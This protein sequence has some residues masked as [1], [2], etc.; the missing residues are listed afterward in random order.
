MQITGTTGAISLDVDKGIRLAEDQWIGLGSTLERVQFDGSL[1]RIDIEAADVTVDDGKWIGIDG[2]SPRIRYTD[3]APGILDVE[4]ANVR[5]DD[6]TWFGLGSTIERFEFQGGD[7]EVNLMGAELGIGTLAPSEALD[8]NGQI[9]MRT[10]GA[11]GYIPVSSANGTMTWTD[12]ATLGFDVTTASNGL[13]EVVNDIQLG[14]SLNQ[15]TTIAQTSFTLDFTSTA[16]DGFSVDGTTFSVDAANDKVGIGTTTPDAKLNV[17]DPNGPS[18]YLTREDN[19]TAANDVLGSLLFDSTDDSGP[20]TND[21]SAGIRAYASVDHGNS[22]K[23]AHLAFFT[24]D[25]VPAATAATERMRI[26]ANGYVG[27]GTTGPTQ[28]LDVNGSIRMR[29]GTTTA[30]WIP[31]SSG[32]GTMVWTNPAAYTGDITA[33][34]AGTGLT[35]G[36][37]SGALTVNAVGDN[38]LTTNADDID[39]GGALNQATTITQ[40]ANKMTFNLNG[41]GDFDI[42]DNGTSAFFV[43]DDGNVGIGTTTPVGKLHVVGNTAGDGGWDDDGILVQNTGAAGEAAVSF[44]NSVTGVNYWQTGLNQSEHYDI[45]YGTSFTNGNSKIRIESTGN[46]GIGTVTPSQMLDVSG[47]I[48]TTTGYRISN[49]AT[50]G[51]YLR[52]NGTRFV[53]SAILVGDLPTITTA[54]GWTDDGTVVRLTTAADN[55]GIGTASPTSA[56]EIYGDQ[57]NLEISNTGETDAGI[58]FNDAQATTSQTFQIMFNSSDED[59]HFRSDQVT[60]VMTL[61][62]DGDVGIGTANP[63]QKLDVQGNIMHTGSMMSRGANYSSTWMNFNEDVYGNS[64]ILG[65]GGLT[66]VGAGESAANASAGIGV[67]GSEVLYLT[68]DGG[69]EFKTSMQ[70][71]W[72][73]RVNAMTIET[74]GDVG[75]GITNPDD[76]LDVGGNAQVSGYLKVGNPTVTATTRYGS[77]TFF[78]TTAFSEEDGYQNSASL[79]TLTIPS[80]AS[81]LTVTKVVYSFNGYHDDGNEEHR[82]MVRLGTTDFGS[83]SEVAGNGYVPVD[84]T[85]TSNHSTNFT[86]AQTVYFRIWDEDCWNCGSDKFHVLNAVVTVYYSFSVAAQTGDIVAQG[87][88]FSS[89]LHSTNQIGDVAEYFN[90]NPV[91]SVH[92]SVGMIVSFSQGSDATFQPAASAYDQLLAGVVSENPSVLLNNPSEGLP[93]ALT[94]RVKIRLKPNGVL[95]KSGDFITSSDIPGLGMKAEQPGPV[96]GF[97]ITNQ[98]PGEDLVEVLLQPGRFYSPTTAIQSSQ[99]IPETSKNEVKLPRRWAT[100]IEDK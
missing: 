45:S 35:G 10:G 64:L 90:V 18:I 67:P 93:V 11:S 70:G 86:S 99:G 16:V 34:T 84:W 56:L 80:G 94:G 85:N 7:G 6:N 88:V 3:G 83:I 9:R 58:I 27:I 17:G 24:K 31:V 36:G 42:Q 60:D 75:I 1:N 66:V 82:A 38:G 13:T 40:G 49:T 39:L 100:V 20:S 98:V 69:I 63:V 76:K 68:S 14:G 15:H 32:D 43:R 44:N 55:V 2:S 37:T 78:L 22:N 19:T 41:T 54:G 30:G 46:I 12:P 62:N 81:S 96:I 73:S 28:L 79:G 61:E 53:S 26:Q 72:A 95:I 71:G 65:G 59:L 50:A 47:D 91:G 51:Q 8:V 57:S 4:A 48:N 23:G 74:A 29:G 21:A 25:N 77:R 92:P 89:S 87:T 5:V 52:G 97:A 33:V